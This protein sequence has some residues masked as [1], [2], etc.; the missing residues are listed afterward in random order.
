MTSANIIE[1][2]ARNKGRIRKSRSPEAM[3]RCSISLLE[4]D[5]E[6]IPPNV[7]DLRTARIET[8]VDD[9]RLALRLALAIFATLIPND[10]KN[11]RDAVRLVARHS[12]GSDGDECRA[13]CRLLTGEQLSC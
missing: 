8:L 4:R 6:S 2:P 11:I 5:G 10:K 13:L 9:G 1:F 7:A 12:D 3:G